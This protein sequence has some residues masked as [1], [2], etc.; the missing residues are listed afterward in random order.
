MEKVMQK[1]EEIKQIL[2]SLRK[3]AFYVGHGK[4]NDYMSIEEVQEIKSKLEK[5]LEIEKEYERTNT[6]KEKELIYKRLEI[7]KTFTVKDFI[8]LKI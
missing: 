3:L 5:I 6:D 4:Y 8:D 1:D 2:D 7:Y